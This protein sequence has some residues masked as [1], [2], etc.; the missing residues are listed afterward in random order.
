MG[1][2]MDVLVIC[3]SALIASGLTL[4]SGFGLGTILTPAFAL[5]FPVATAIAM[6]A[7]VHL[8]NNLFKIGLVGRDANWSVVMRFGLPAALAAIMGAML[9]SRVAGMAPWVSYELLGQS[10]EVTPVKAAIGV[11]IAAF[12][13][14]ELSPAFARMAFPARWLP[15]G[16]LISGFFGGLSGNQGALRSAFLVKAGLSKESY[17]G[18]S[19]VCAV[20]V[21]TVRIAVYGFALHSSWAN[22]MDSH[23]GFTVAAATLSAFLGAFFGKRL[24][25]KVTLRLVELTVASMMVLVGGGLA[26]GLI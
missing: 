18:T 6:T 10:H 26:S 4:F 1:N 21:D 2:A 24:L 16:G 5:F 3:I 8:A 9:L 25:K 15:V 13:L 7:V 17:V 23:A 11:V 14:L 19:A 12:A 20:V 22:P